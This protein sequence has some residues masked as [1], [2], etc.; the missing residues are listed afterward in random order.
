MSF[1]S[2]SR[3]MVSPATYSIQVCHDVGSIPSAGFAPVHSHAKR[4]HSPHS[5]GAMIGDA[6][7]PDHFLFKGGF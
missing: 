3:F 6:P 5:E 4:L 1:V 7:G 2:E